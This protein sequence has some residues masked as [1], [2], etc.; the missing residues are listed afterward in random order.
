MLKKFQQREFL[1][2]VVGFVFFLKQLNQFRLFFNCFNLLGYSYQ[3]TKTIQALAISC[4]Q[5]DTIWV[6]DIVFNHITLYIAI[7]L[8]YKYTQLLTLD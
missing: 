7:N 5:G 8:P 3:S 2:M 6:N 1:S 4:R